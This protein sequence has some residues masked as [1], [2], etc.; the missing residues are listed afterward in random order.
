MATLARYAAWRLLLE[1]LRLR[2]LAGGHPVRDLLDAQG[3]AHALMNYGHDNQVL[4]EWDDH[5]RA[6]LLREGRASEG[7]D[8]ISLV[9]QSPPGDLELPPIPNALADEL[10]MPSSW[11]Q[12]V[13]DLLAE[14]RQLILY[15]PPGTGKTYL[16]AHLGRHFAGNGGSY[17][18]VQFHPSYTYEDF[19]EGYRPDVQSD[20]TLRFKLVDGV[21][22]EIAREA[23]EHPETPHLLV[24]DEINRGNLAKIFGELFFL[25]EYRDHAVRL[26]YSSEE[27]SLPRNLYIVGTMNTADKSIALV[28]AA[29]RRR[30]YFVGLMPTRAPVND[31]LRRWLDRHGHDP[32]PAALLDELNAEIADADF[33]IGPSYLM[34]DPHKLEHAWEHAILPLLEE[35]YYG[36]GQDVSKRFGL[37]ALNA[38]ITARANETTSPDGGDTDP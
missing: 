7:Q 4:A 25:L 22:R 17:R 9:P 36:T 29:L 19:F 15:G 18:L 34:T 21:L 32:A 6:V 27:F 33:S 35:H 30:F 13:L 20:G 2:M 37:D 11:L 12:K 5:D 14:K 8:V 10:L 23:Q 1:E 38:R 16:A 26:Q 28:D 24:V 31:V 3:I